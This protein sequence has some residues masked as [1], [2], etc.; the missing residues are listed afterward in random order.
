MIDEW[1][2]K[3]GADIVERRPI[4]Y[5]MQFRLTRGPEAAIVNIYEGRKGRRVVVQQSSKLADELRELAGQPAA[6]AAPKLPKWK[7]WCGSD[8]S[9]KGDLLGPLVV[10]AVAV[11]RDVARTLSRM[12]VRDSKQLTNAQ[13]R[14]LDRKIRDAAPAKVVGWMPP[15]YNR[16]YEEVRN[17]NRLL[18]EAHAEAIMG[19]AARQPGLEA[20]VVDQFGSEGT[21]GKALEAAGWKGVLEQRPGADATDVAVGAASIVARAA[22]LRGMEQLSRQEGVILRMGASEDA[23]ESARAFVERHGREALPRVAKMHFKSVAQI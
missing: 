13:A 1:A 16:R 19:V 4:D 2:K 20:A 12:G 22:F 3:L 21:M 7:A 6:P 9:G 23:M 11:T 14:G 5:G 17:L 8:E 18:G 15:E 10:A